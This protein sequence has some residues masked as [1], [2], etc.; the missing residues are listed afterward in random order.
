MYTS[1]GTKAG[2][3]WSLRKWSEEMPNL[4]DIHKMGGFVVSLLWI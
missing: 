1:Q 2:G 4:W 3:F